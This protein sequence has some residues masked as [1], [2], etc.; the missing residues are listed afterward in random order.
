MDTHVSYE[1]LMEEFGERIE[2]SRSH[3]LKTWKGENHDRPAV[4]LSDVNYALC[5]QT[6]IPDDYFT[7]S[8]MF[9]YQMKKIRHHMQTVHDDY[10]PVLHPWYGT[11]VV[12]SAFGVP[13]HFHKGVDPSLGAPI[14]EDTDDIAKL[15]MPDPE[16]DGQMPQVLACIDYMKHHT[17]VPVC[18]T[19]CQGPLNIALSLAGV[20]NLFVWMYEEPEAVHQLMQLCTDVLIN[21]VKV[22][23]QHA[24]HSL[25]GDAYPH[26][27]EMPSQF[28][29]V[30]FADDDVTA[31]NAEQYQTFV[32][33]YNEQLLN[34]FGGGSMHFCGSAEHQ[35][36]GVCAMKG[37]NAL[38]NFCMGNFNQIRMIHEKMRGRGGL[39]ACDFNASDIAWHVENLKQLAKTPEGLILGVFFTPAMALLEGGKYTSSDRNTDRLVAQYETL[40]REAG[41]L[42]AI[43]L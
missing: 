34:A 41:I 43:D 16:S 12:P 29:G 11:T 23:K 33:P 14:L 26:A 17:D 36:E 13:V 2:K 21:W 7:P 4:I 42:P 38:N 19:D 40:L 31:M 3:L 8:V 25:T 18:V 28:G 27:I 10:I 30:A 6:D 1:H 9:E 20:E 24:G 5:G 22:Q 39:M 37:L 35:V 15:C 32:V